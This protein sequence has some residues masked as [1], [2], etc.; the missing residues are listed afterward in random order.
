MKMYKDSSAK[1]YQ[2]HKKKTPKKAHETYQNLSKAEK[3][4]NTVVND[5]NISQ[6]MKNK[7]WL[8]IEKNI[9]K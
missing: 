4:K 8:S 6:K 3:N 7:S 9:I 5:I 2:D 1:Y